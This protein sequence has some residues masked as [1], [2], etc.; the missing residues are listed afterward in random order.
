MEDRNDGTQ[1][2]LITGGSRG[3]GKATVERAAASG[4]FDIVF[5]YRTE[6]E[7]AACLVEACRARDVRASALRVELLDADATKATVAAEIEENGGF[8]AVVH[9]AA[10]TADTNFYFMDDSQWHDV[11][12]ASLNSFYILNKLALGHMIQHRWGRIVTLASVAGEM[13]NRG[14]VNYS[15]A[16]GA[17]I[18]ATKALAREVVRARGVLCN[19]VSPGIIE[20]DMTKDMPDMRKVIPQG[21]YGKPRRGR[22]RRAFPPFRRG[23][24]RERRCAARQWGVLHVSVGPSSGARRRVVI[25]GHGLVSPA[26]VSGQDVEAF[27]A[28]GK[29]AVRVREEVCVPYGLLTRL[30]APVEDFEEA[31]YPRQMRRSMS[32]ISLMSVDA[33]RRAIEQARL[34]EDIVRH[35]R[36]GLSYGVDHGRHVG[37]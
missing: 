27:T 16:K 20:T 23:K 26:G 3:I 31:V 32:R 19:V 22:K 36:T 10:L 34:P 21:R 24:L 1:A 17:L 12:N 6:A 7:E 2:H 14:Q 25:T 9:N 35:P 30:A 29:S 15:A 13:G 5:T 8:D 37:A 4:A 11:L 33:T 28:A 18:S